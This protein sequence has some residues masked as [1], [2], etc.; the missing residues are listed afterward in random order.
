MLLQEKEHRLESILARYKRV[1]LAFS[2]GADSSL[3]LSKAL[4]V[5]GNENILVLTARSC[6]LKQA[7]VEKA[8]T[9]LSRHGYDNQ[10]RHEFVDLQPLSWEEFVQNPSDRCYLCKLRVY[11]LFGD[12]STQH[13][14]TQ[15][16]DGTNHDD[17]HSDRPGLRALR[18]LDIGTPLAEA[19]M[20]KE[21][22]RSLSRDIGLDT[23]DHPSASCLATRIPDNLEITETRIALVDKLES[24]LETMGLNGCRVRLD[25]HSADK[26]YVQVLKKDV[27]E[28]ASLVNRSTLTHL[29]NDSGV[30]KIF[31]D[32]D[33]R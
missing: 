15:I 9:W 19:E 17:L 5:L 4:E 27:G 12:L 3:L 1:A 13:G 24:Y 11:Q 26:V 23:W 31:L 29:F 2:G 25:R 32:L 7:E 33:G 20:T 6:L 21:E 10:V 16:I 8:S 30:K 14:I 22:V 18:E 28:L